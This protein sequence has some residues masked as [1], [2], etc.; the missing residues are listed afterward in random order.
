MVAL[1]LEQETTNNNF[2]PHIRIYTQSNK[3]Q[4]VNYYYGFYDPL[5]YPFLFP[6]RQN[7]WHCGIQ[8]IEQPMHKSKKKRS[9]YKNDQLLSLSNMCSIDELLDMEA[10]ILQNKKQRMNII[11]C[12]EYYCY[13][14][15]IRD[16]EE[17]INLHSGRLFQQYSIDEFV[18][19]ETQ[20]LDFTFLN[21]DLFRVDVP[22]GIIDIPKLGEREASK[23]GKKNFLPLSFTDDPGDMHRHYM[24]AIALVQHFGR[25]DIFLTMT[26][27][28][29][30]PEIKEH[31]LS[32]N[33]AQNRLDL[34]SRVFRSKVEEM[35]TNI[36][37]INI[38]GKVAAFMYTIEF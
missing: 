34:V 29:S 13:K 1:W 38:F 12:R 5:Q 30:G 11:S 17:N 22:Q 14:I 21:Q 35:K 19:L 15:Q 28:S 10:Q 18:K 16:D 31:M 37:K 24:D 33:E 7:R 20:R 25:P 26:C 3:S 8:K 27:N 2:T 23:I 36:L 9:C 32:T 4:L 6:Y